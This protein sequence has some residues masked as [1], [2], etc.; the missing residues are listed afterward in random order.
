MCLIALL[1]FSYQSHSTRSIQSSFE[2]RYPN[3]VAAE[4]ECLLCHQFS[5]GGLNW[6]SYGTDLWKST[7]ANAAFEDI[8]NLD[9]DGDGLTNLYEIENGRDPGWVKGLQNT[10]TYG[11][12]STETEQAPAIFDT[13]GGFNE[14][15]E[16]CFYV[17]TDFEETS[18]YCSIP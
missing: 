4:R 10:Y 15:E 5:Y 9:S 18:I 7:S 11:D 3:S 2:N 13:D 8:E 16:V 12:G 14:D 6:N 17:N 1:V